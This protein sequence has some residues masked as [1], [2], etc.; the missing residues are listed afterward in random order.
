[1]LFGSLAISFVSKV[2]KKDDWSII[3]LQLRAFLA[4]LCS[5]SVKKYKSKISYL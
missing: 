5:R 2:S 4:I 3:K 1:M